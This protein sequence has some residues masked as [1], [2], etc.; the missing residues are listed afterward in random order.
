MHIYFIYKIKM[1]R[2][3]VLLGVIHKELEPGVINDAMINASIVEQGYK[4][5]AGRLAQ[6]NPI[7]Y[8]ELSAIRLEFQSNVFSINVF[9]YFFYKHINEFYYLRYFKD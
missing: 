8:N 5:E 3:K 9:Y 4:G 6:L 2:S 1:E 7:V